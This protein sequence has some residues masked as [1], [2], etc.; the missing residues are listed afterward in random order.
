MTELIT[1]HSVAKFLQENPEL[2]TQHAELFSS[3]EVPHPHQSRA[4][5]L[6]E[7]QILTLRD[8]LREFEFRLADMVRNASQNETT[9]EKLNQWCSRILA[10]PNV[11]RLPGEVALGLA[12][13]FDL[14]EAALRVWGLDLPNEGVAAP[15]SED[16]HI[17]ADGLV[18]PYCG[19]NTEFVAATW[20]RNKPASLAIIALRS[21]GDTATFGLLVLGSDD[22]QRFSPEMGTQFLSVVSRLAGAALSRL[23]HPAIV[24]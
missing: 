6:G 7:R 21:P 23:K 9:T 22:P 5:S 14:Q 11:T 10:E 4:I 12:E 2:F 15:V 17:F 1:A 16:V 24:V 18:S 20:L 3:L 19:N 13:V 8:R